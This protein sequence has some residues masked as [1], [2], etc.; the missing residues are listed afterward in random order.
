MKILQLKKY[1][2]TYQKKSNIHVKGRSES[3]PRALGHRSIMCVPDSDNGRDYLNFKLKR[4]GA[5]LC[6]IILDSM[7]MIF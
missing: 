3:G 5:D 7:L 6:P 1:L 4:E 2:I